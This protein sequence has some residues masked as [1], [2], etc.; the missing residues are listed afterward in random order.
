MC[1]WCIGSYAFTVWICLHE[2][3]MAHGVAL[4]SHGI[5]ESHQSKTI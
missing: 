4:F 3:A 5:Y 1:N 2:M